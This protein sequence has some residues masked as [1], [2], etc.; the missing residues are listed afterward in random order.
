MQRRRFLG[1]AVLCISMP[2]LACARAE[3]SGEREL[4]EIT[5]HRDPG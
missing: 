3:A 5:V 1:F 2:T 4:I